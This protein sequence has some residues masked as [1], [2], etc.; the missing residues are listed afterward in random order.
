MPLTSA[1]SIDGVLMYWSCNMASRAGGQEE[2][3]LELSTAPNDEWQRDHW[4][5][6][7]YTRCSSNPLTR[8][9]LAAGLGEGVSVEVK[10]YHDDTDI[11]FDIIG[12]EASHAGEA[13]PLMN[14]IKRPRT[15]SAESRPQPPV[16]TCGVHT[17][18]SRNACWARNDALRQAQLLRAGCEAGGTD[19]GDGPL[20]QLR[21][22]YQLCESGAQHVPCRGDIYAQAIS[23]RALT[24]QF[25]SNTPLPG[26]TGDL[27]LGGMD[28]LRAAGLGLVVPRTVALWEY[29]HELISSAVLVHAI[30]REEIVRRSL[31]GHLMLAMDRLRWVNSPGSRADAV[32]L[33]CDLVY[34]QPGD[35][36]IVVQGGL[37]G[38]LHQM[39]DVIPIT[40]TGPAESRAPD[41]TASASIRID[42]T[43]NWAC[44]TM[45]GEH[46]DGKN[47]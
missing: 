24:R 46:A 6:A 2:L 21:W 3:E 14:R 5:Q 42:W 15:I 30:Q 41:Q 8:E 9:R 44:A 11:W 20:A 45:I 33:W 13:E 18:V 28:S 35:A 27:L 26:I 7:I 47:E 1:G 31:P 36:E 16:C 43:N 38:G 40:W 17:M 4:R 23:C 39:H 34:D 19:W 29:P 22:V 37:A 32:A 25:E 12:I 10:A